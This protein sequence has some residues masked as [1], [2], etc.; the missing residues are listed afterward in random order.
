MMTGGLGPPNSSSRNSRAGS[1]IG[2]LLF[3]KRSAGERLLAHCFCWRPPRSC[4]GHTGGGEQR[5]GRLP[6][7]AKV[8]PR[9]VLGESRRKRRWR[10]RR[11]LGPLTQLAADRCRHAGG[12]DEQQRRDQ[13]R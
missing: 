2:I 7:L 10:K 4:G 1:A 11:W 13:E 5:R 9:L 8:V 12:Q 6:Q 3:A